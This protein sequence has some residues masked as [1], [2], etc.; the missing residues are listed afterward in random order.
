LNHSEFFQSWFLA[1]D[2]DKSFG[3]KIDIFTQSLAGK[4]V[5]INP[6]FN[7]IIK[8][9]NA[10]SKII[11][12]VADEM[13]A[14]RPT[15][16]V[17]LLPIFDGKEGHCYETQAKKAKFM[18]IA[19]FPAN[20]FRFV[21]PEAFSVGE[22]FT[23]GYFHGKVGLYLAANRASLKI[24][25]I[26]LS[27]LTEDLLEW[28]KT[29]CSK[30]VCICQST[31]SKFNERIHL[32]DPPRTTTWRDNIQ[33]PLSAAI[34]HYYDFSIESSSDFQNLKRYIKDVSHLHLLSSANKHDRL[35]GAIGIL[36]NH[37]I[38]FIKK[39]DPD[40]MQDI[41]SDLRKAAFWS[42]YQVWQQRMHLNRVYWRNKVPP[43]WKG[44]Q[45]PLNACK[46]PFHYLDLTH[47]N[48][49][50]TLGTC[51]C[52]AQ[53]IPKKRKR[54]LD[55]GTNQK[56]DNWFNQSNVLNEPYL[57]RPHKIPKPN[58]SKTQS[59]IEDTSGLDHKHTNKSSSI[60]SGKSVKHNPR[61][62]TSSEVTLQ[63]QDRKKRFKA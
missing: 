14:K 26:N 24:D 11:R 1:Y 31:L 22:N 18:E 44:K 59:R 7:N 43:S 46:T 30:Q 6:P 45:D 21:A 60:F 42:S 52:S 15:R 12:K 3:A 34:Y 33:Y 2:S 4:N 20:S 58:R 62:R 50:P 57:N 10:I 49:P 32:S 63:E 48:V 54:A 41:L 17:L 28:S 13:K 37:L 25:P 8:K 53:K 9:E 61:A 5:Y 36:P 29:A 56:L 23:P 27:K 51:N 47:R 35:A 39:V 38:Q 16:V 19:T 55:D 40:H